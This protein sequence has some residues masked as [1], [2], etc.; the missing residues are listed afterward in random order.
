MSKQYSPNEEIL[1]RH[2]DI[3][4]ALWND[5]PIDCWRIM[6]KEAFLSGADDIYVN[7]VRLGTR[8]IDKCMPYRMTPEFEQLIET[9]PPLPI[10]SYK[11]GDKI[12]FD[13]YPDGEYNST[14]VVDHLDTFTFLNVSVNGR[15]ICF[16]EGESWALGHYYKLPRPFNP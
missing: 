7:A 8:A 9:Q 15:L 5:R 4:E 6:M 14:G 11:V 1:F 16:E 13:E 2:F 10:T 12:E 3:P